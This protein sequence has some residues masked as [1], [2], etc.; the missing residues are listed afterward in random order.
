MYK[1]F[2]VNDKV[3]SNS[4][5]RPVNAS[6]NSNMRVAL[7]S[8]ERARAVLNGFNAS[9]C[10]KMG[11]LKSSRSS[12]KVRPIIYSHKSG[13]L[14]ECQATLNAHTGIDFTTFQRSVILGQDTV[15]NFSTSARYVIIK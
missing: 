3:T 9:N 1:K 11:N 12:R 7:K 5:P 4:Q 8:S 2:A 13:E 14:N 15:S 10:K 6:L